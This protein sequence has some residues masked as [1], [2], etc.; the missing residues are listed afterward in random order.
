MCFLW[1]ELALLMSSWFESV[2]PD[3]RR[4]SNRT[5]VFLFATL[6]RFIWLFPRN[7][8]VASLNLL[9]WR[10]RQQVAPKLPNYMPSHCTRYAQQPK[11]LR[12][13]V[14][15]TCWDQLI[16]GSFITAEVAYRIGTRNF[17]IIMFLGSKVRPVRK[18]E[19][20]T[21]ICEPI[22]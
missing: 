1:T 13:H 12:F 5:D 4:I 2:V 10:W 6:R 21:A 15:V 3:R 22:V 8:L 7:P 16:A 11:M 20:L 14:Y 9:L 19:N 17:K 18:A